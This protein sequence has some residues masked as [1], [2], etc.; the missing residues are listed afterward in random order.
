MDSF[1]IN[2]TERVF[3]ISNSDSCVEYDYIPYHNVSV[4][5]PINTISYAEYPNHQ[6]CILI[7]AELRRNKMRGNYLP[8]EYALLAW[9]VRVFECAGKIIQN[10]EPSKFDLDHSWLP[11]LVALTRRGVGP[12]RAQSL[13]AKKGIILVIEEH[14]PGTY[15][16]GA[17]MRGPHDHPVIGLT[18]RYDRLDHFWFV[19]FH[20]I[21]HIYIHLF[22]GTCYNFFDDDTANSVDEIELEADEFALN[23]LIPIDHWECALSRFALSEEAVRLDAQNLNIAESILAGRIRRERNNYTILN[24]LIQSGI[25]EQ[26]RNDS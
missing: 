5:S 19:L 12:R 20:E 18:L 14:L 17:A 16:D 13:L 23:A 8:N 26:I 9:Q 2:A 11:E 6:N 25:R 3:H 22:Q 7:S 1:F 15:L 21:A 4:F 10:K 24:E